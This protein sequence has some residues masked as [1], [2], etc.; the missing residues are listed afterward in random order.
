MKIPKRPGE[1]ANDI[2]K[3]RR[4]HEREARR[5]CRGVRE[6]TFKA[7]LPADDSGV[8]L[9]D[10]VAYMQSHDYVFMPAG[11]FWP[12]A[13]V[14]ARL[15]CLPLFDKDGK[16]CRR[17]DRHAEDNQGERVA[18]QTCARR[19][20][21]LGAGAAAARPGQA[22]QRRRLDR[23]ERRDRAQ[24][25]SAAAIC[26]A[27]RRRPSR[28]S[29]TSGGSIPTKPTTSSSFS[30]IACSGRTRRSI[31]G[32]CSAAFRAS[33]RT[34]CSSPSNMRSARGTSSRSRRSRCSAGS[35]DSS[36]ASC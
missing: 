2:L 21:D 31:T 26:T 4:A 27:T 22:D 1:D 9:K 23:P 36:R 28:G 17:E 29:H 6:E 20:N 34:P 32:S 7:N 18:R 33:A 5:F 24:S 8:Q 19:A 16:P 10:F 25:V 11:D 13:R 3:R 35:T 14:D 15:P 12:A 30:P